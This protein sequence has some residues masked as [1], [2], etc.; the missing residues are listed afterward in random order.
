M[1]SEVSNHPEITLT[2]YLLS[3]TPQTVTVTGLEAARTR[4]QSI[5]N[6]GL[7]VPTPD[8]GQM[9]WPPHRITRIASSVPL[10]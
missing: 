8:G 2:V 6:C 7:S 10:N 5:I 1:E 3:E 4:K 9:T